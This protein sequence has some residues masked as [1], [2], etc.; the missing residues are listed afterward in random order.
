MIRTFMLYENFDYMVFTRDSAGEICSSIDIQ[1]IVH[2]VQDIVYYTFSG[3]S[4]T[5]NLTRFLYQ[6]FRTGR[7]DENDYF[8]D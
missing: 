3:S 8:Y 1:D 4:R 7:S 2:C 6:I 5:I